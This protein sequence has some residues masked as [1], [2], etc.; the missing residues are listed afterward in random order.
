MPFAT[1][2]SVARLVCT[3][4]VAVAV[5][6]PRVARADD[7]VTEMARQR[8]R[9]GVQF[10]DQR[11]YEKA[12]LAF[13]QSYAIKPHPA[14]L[15]NLAQSEL[16]AG[17]P[18]D[19]ANHFSEYLRSSGSTNESEKQEAELG[20][21][22]AKTK[23]AE[24]T[25]AVDATGA[26]VSVDGQEKGTSPLPG[27]LYMSPGSHSIEA[28]SN[29]R[30][31]SKTVSVLAGQ[32]ISVT[33][34]FRSAAAPP[35]AAAGGGTPQENA[36]PAPQTEPSRAEEE[37]AAEEAPAQQPAEV[38]TGGRMGFFPWLFSHP[39][40]LLLAGV[41]LAGVGTGIGT[42]IASH[43]S[44]AN[45]NELQDKILNQRNSDAA[46]GYFGPAA[47]SDPGSVFPCS[48]SADKKNIPGT[49]ENT[50]S[51]YSSTR[52]DEY[53]NA[54]QQYQSSSD[55]GNTLKT[56]A[57]VSG[58]IGG[59]AL[60][61]TIVYYFLDSKSSTTNAA[62]TSGVRAAVIPWGSSEG[63]GFGVFGRF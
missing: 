63:G 14:T 59:A 27:P 32:A 29:D 23:V 34:S 56:V 54:C 24:V 36:A 53:A 20:F 21:T 39:G 5:C 62:G 3:I 42:A 33:L 17:H 43:Q 30:A 47:R 2:R 49:V 38:T 8:F 55:N 1:L 35:P 40:G 18:D 25:V 16:R 50:L 51:K 45:A 15:L 46:N 52:L 31:A 58:A 9:E 7:D 41:G 11:Q 26:Q 57:I 48:L 60:A 13:L 37:P 6:L 28:R 12:R 19:A 61:G 22:A 44:F 10:Y 4:A